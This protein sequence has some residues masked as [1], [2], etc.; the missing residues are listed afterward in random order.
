MPEVIYKIGGVSA[1]G[2]VVGP[3][4]KFDWTVPDGELHR[5]HNCYP[6]LCC[7]AP[8]CG[9]GACQPTS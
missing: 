1:D 4:G 7:H 3:D 2:Y 6:A 5:F 8:L 9:D